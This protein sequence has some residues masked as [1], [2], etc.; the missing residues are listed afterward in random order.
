M[1]NLLE[2]K[3]KHERKRRN[4]FRAATTGKIPWNARGIEDCVRHLNKRYSQLSDEEQNDWSPYVE[5]LCFIKQKYGENRGTLYALRM[6][7]IINFMTHYRERLK[8]ENLIKTD[9]DGTMWWS[10]HLADAF[11]KL[12]F[13]IRSF[14]YAD[15]KN[16]IKHCEKPS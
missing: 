10:G 13:T 6:G 7:Q 2:P 14:R 15:V 1:R 4:Y 8:R 3:N 5:S 9:D 16:Y 12:P 11:A